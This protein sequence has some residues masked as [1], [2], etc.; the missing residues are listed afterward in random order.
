M[1]YSRI[2]AT[3][4]EALPGGVHVNFTVNDVR[5]QLYDASFVVRPS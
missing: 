4:P 1:A 5:V 3:I 2:F